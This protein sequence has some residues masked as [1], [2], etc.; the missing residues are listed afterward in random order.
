MEQ[1]LATPRSG[2]TEEIRVI[3]D[4]WWKKGGIDHFISL[5]T[6]KP[7]IDQTAVAKED[8]L[9]LSAAIPGCRTNFGLPYNPYGERREDYAFN[10]PMGIFDFRRDAVV[11]IGRELW[12]TL[13]GAGCYAELLQI[14][15]A[16]G[17]ETRRKIHALR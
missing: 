16:V 13:G 6:V 17:A 5:K 10:P 15:A 7:N 1:I 8:C 12:D 14:A 9:H 4:L 2:R 11:L 3:S